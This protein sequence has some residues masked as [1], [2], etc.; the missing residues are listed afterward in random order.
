MESGPCNNR[1]MA[2]L[3]LCYC[4]NKNGAWTVRVDKPHGNQPYHK[5]HVHITKKGLKGEYSWNEDGSQHDKHRFPRSEQCIVSAKEHA[6]NAL[7]IN[8]G[9]L[10]FITSIAGGVHVSILATA[11]LNDRPRSIFSSYLRVAEVLVIF[12]TDMGLAIAITKANDE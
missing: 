6:A 11:E 2:N 8:A 3:I 5:R 7:G 12:G 10:S 9:N 1:T 4:A